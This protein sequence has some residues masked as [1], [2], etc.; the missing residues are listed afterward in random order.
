MLARTVACGFKKLRYAVPSPPK[1]GEKVADRPD[2]GFLARKECEQKPPHP[3]PQVV[4]D[5]LTC[6][7][8]RQL[9]NDLGERGQKTPIDPRIRK[10]KTC[11]SGLNNGC[12]NPQSLIPETLIFNMQLVDDPLKVTNLAEDSK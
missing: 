12:R 2:E 10:S 9:A 3:L 7:M 4:C 6:N 5:T 1:S 8:T 11:D